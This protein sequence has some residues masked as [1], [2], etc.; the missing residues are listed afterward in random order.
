MEG[1]LPIVEG[2][3]L[4]KFNVFP[5]L[6]LRRRPVHHLQLTRAV[7]AVVVTAAAIEATCF[8]CN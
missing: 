2:F 7:M 1:G 6:G 3:T 8:G 5:G 4:S